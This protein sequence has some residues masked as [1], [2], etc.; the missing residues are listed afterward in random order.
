MPFMAFIMAAIPP[1]G[2]E[3]AAP[4]TEPNASVISD[5]RESPLRR[6]DR[7]KPAP[8]IVEIT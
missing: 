5:I 1:R 2:P 4:A 8:K 3:A 7:Y 6:Q